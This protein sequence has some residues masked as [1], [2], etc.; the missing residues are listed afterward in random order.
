MFWHCP[1]IPENEV[2]SKLAVLSSEWYF[3]TFAQTLSIL[4]KLLIGGMDVLIHWQ[5][6]PQQPK[7]VRD[8]PSQPVK[9]LTVGLGT[10][11]WPRFLS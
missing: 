10:A 2:V 7:Y 5:A 8:Q 4:S 1:H 11:V 6:G 9:I 3:L